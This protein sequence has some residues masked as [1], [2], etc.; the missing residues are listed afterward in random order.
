MRS[1]HSDVGCSS[2][3]DGTVKSSLDHGDFLHIAIQIAAGMEYLSSHF[4][5][6]KDLAARN[7]LIGEQL[8]VKISD[9]GLS[10]EIYSADYYR[11]QSKSLLPIRWMPPE[12]IMY[13]KF[14]SDSDIWSFGVV[15]WEIFSFGLQPY[16]GFSNQE[17]IEM[18]RKRQLLPC[19][20]DCPPRMY[21]LMTECWNEIPSRRPRFKDIHYFFHKLKNIFCFLDNVL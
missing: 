10:R 2:D 5:V 13:G 1:P 7:I 21:S 12:A 4:F 11:V 6:H 17:V 16:Y 9:L 3:E 20:E 19:S 14:S 8:H 15:L 18:V